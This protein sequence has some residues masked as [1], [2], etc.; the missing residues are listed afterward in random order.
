M[1]EFCDFKVTLDTVRN[2]IRERL[3]DLTNEVEKAFEYVN[4]NSE[5]AIGGI[6][7]L[8]SLDHDLDEIYHCCRLDHKK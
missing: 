8:L 7:E 1:T 3:D 5:R 2:M 4:G 6:E